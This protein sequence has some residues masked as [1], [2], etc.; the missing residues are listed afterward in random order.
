MKAEKE[1]KI[2]NHDW[3]IQIP[4]DVL[5][6]KRLSRLS[7]ILYGYLAFRQGKNTFGWP[8]I[9][10]IMKDLGAS[11]RGIFEALKQLERYDYVIKKAGDQKTPNNYYTGKNLC[12]PRG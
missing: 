6:D 5:E 12:N 9:K 2:E 11:R 3:F 7:Q 1:T 4:A 10:R 8:S